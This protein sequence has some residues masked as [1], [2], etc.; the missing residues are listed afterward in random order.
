MKKILVT[1]ALAAA[2]SLAF[3]D[4]GAGAGAGTDTKTNSES[5][6]SAN[7]QGGAGGSGGAVSGVNASN[8]LNV[9]CL[10]N[11]ASTDQGSKD[12]AD[13]G[14]QQ[15]LINAQAARDIAGTRIRN[16]PS[17]SG[18]ALTSSN[19]T[20]MGSSSGSANGPGIGIS[21]GSTWTD[22]NCKMLKNARELWNMGMKFAAMKLMCK[23]SDNRAALMDTGFDCDEVTPIQKKT[24]ATV[25]T[26][27]AS[28]EF[29]DPVIRARL[30]LAPLAVA[31]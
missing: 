3:A 10:V 16:T 26:S 29:T 21:I 30:G 18:P 24:V 2:C 8:G 15:A 20:C 19:D 25:S 7:S 11:C 5:T 14:V 31:K 13:S 22:G 27:S 1:L 28:A 4:A 23:D 12:L 17:V 6:S 9:G